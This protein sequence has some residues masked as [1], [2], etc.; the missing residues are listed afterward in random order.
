[1]ADALLQPGV[2]GWL[3]SGDALRGA[4]YRFN[5]TRN[6]TPEA[7][8]V[9]LPHSVALAP[10][11]A[12]MPVFD[13]ISASAPLTRARLVAGLRLE[14][15]TW[16]TRTPQWEGVQIRT[17]ARYSNSVVA[18]EYDIRGVTVGDLPGLAI[19]PTQTLVGL[20]LWLVAADGSGQRSYTRYA[21][22][23]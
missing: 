6:G 18:V 17:V 14:W 16:A 21:I 5:Y 7:R 15:S 3:G 23:P 10:D 8:F 19:D 2:V 13:G 20:E 12:L 1:L 22:A 11:R 4:R 9:Y